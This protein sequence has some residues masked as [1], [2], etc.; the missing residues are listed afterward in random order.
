M[1]IELKPPR[2]FSVTS[3]RGRLVSVMMLLPFLFLAMRLR[4]FGPQKFRPFAPIV[5]PATTRTVAR[6]LQ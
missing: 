5:T 4:S 3:G 1:A 6:Q 2:I